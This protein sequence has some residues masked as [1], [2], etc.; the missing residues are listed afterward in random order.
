MS[1]HS[2]KEVNNLLQYFKRRMKI[3]LG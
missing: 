2:Y 1:M 3:C